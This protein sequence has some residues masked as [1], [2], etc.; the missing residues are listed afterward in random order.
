MSIA[1]YTNILRVIRW[2]PVSDGSYGGSPWNAGENWWS[3]FSHTR[4]LSET[5]WFALLFRLILPII[6]LTVCT[7]KCSPTLTC[8]FFIFVTCP[9]LFKICFVQSR[10]F[11]SFFD[12]TQHCDYWWQHLFC[13]MIYRQ[14]LNIFTDC[15][16]VKTAMNIF[17][18]SLTW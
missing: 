12:W 18:L 11:S 5:A 3:M 14:L 7:W 15:K 16:S 10:M 6:L 1:G 8:C 17:F 13:E 9:D 4:L 2:S